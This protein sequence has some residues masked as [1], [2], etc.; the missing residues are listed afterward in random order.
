[1]IGL[2]NVVKTFRYGKGRRRVILDGATG[3]FPDGESVGVLGRNGAGKS[4]LMK[5]LGGSMRPDSGDVLRTGSVS[6]PLGFS[7][8]FAGSMT[9]RANLRFASRIYGKDWREVSDF[10]EDFAELGRAMDQPVSTYSSGMKAR[11]AF[12]LSM[13]IDFD[14]YLVDELTAVGDA[15]FRDKCKKVFEERKSR[16]SLIVVSHSI[17][18]VKRNCTAAAVLDAGRLKFFKSVSDAVKLYQEIC[19]KPPRTVLVQE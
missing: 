15:S 12:G 14:C 13:A 11:L 3:A 10:V 9:G 1:M 16:S 7:G 6:W 8:C 19:K 18:T 17:D 4:T 2:W 5:I